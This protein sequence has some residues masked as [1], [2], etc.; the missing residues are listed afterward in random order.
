MH[1]KATYTR[2]ANR[3]LNILHNIE[4]YA[5]ILK[6]LSWNI[7]IPATTPTSIPK[8]A[9]SAKPRFPALRREAVVISMGH[10]NACRRSQSE[11]SIP[12]QQQASATSEKYRQRYSLKSFPTSQIWNR[13]VRV[14][15]YTHLPDMHGTAPPGTSLPQTPETCCQPARWRCPTGT[16][17]LR[18][19][20]GKACKWS[21]KQEIGKAHP[22]KP[23]DQRLSILL[24]LIREI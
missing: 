21:K 22:H 16:S 20:P 19:A 10:R 1:G 12:A 24:F 4:K 2:N 17:S 13:Q 6:P 15:A 23:S 3:I 9:A 7:H 14:S 5:V 18:E 11:C 8:R